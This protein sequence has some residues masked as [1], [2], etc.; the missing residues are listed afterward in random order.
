MGNEEAYRLKLDVC[1]V[2]YKS[3]ARQKRPDVS[4]TKLGVV[5]LGLL[6]N[7]AALEGNHFLLHQKRIRVVNGQGQLLGTVKGRYLNEPPQLPQADLMICVGA[8]DDG[9]MPQTV[10]RGDA[11][12]AT[13]VRA[14]SVA[15]W[16][17][18]DAVTDLWRANHNVA[19]S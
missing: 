13:I 18:E 5:Q 19:A 1:G 10:V 2:P 17:T 16:E 6:A 14:T 3:V 11:T 8:T 4:M 7:G 9:N 12:A 15:Q